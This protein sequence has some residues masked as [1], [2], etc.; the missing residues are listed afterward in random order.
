MFITVGVFTSFSQATTDGGEQ[1]QLPAAIFIGAQQ[2]LD[3][4][5]LTTQA[6]DALQQFQLFPIV[7][8]H[9]FCLFD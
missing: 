8:S 3:G 5:Q 7:K 9:G 1:H 2:A 4:V 6:A